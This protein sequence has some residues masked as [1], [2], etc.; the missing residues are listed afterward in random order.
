MEQIDLKS[1][2]G[3]KKE[4][5]H[6]PH[7]NTPTQKKTRLPKKVFIFLLLFFGWRQPQA[8]SHFAFAQSFCYNLTGAM[9]PQPN[10]PIIPR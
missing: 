4:T 10:A 1:I 9:S 7:P 6:A 3:K 8:R 5:K 2:I